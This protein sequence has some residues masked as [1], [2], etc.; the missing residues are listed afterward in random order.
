M[1]SLGFSVWT[2]GKLAPTEGKINVFTDG[3]DGEILTV[4]N[5]PNLGINIFGSSTSD[6]LQ[7][8]V[9][10]NPICHVTSNII[11]LNVANLYDKLKHVEH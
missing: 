8:V 4:W 1:P 6:M 10:S 9:W 7:L 2:L 5:L 3:F 11:F